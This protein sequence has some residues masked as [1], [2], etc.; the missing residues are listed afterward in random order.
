MHENVSNL[1][2]ILY[3]KW[4]VKGKHLVCPFYTNVSTAN[5]LT[6]LLNFFLIY[7]DGLNTF[8]DSFKMWE[9]KGRCRLIGSL[10]H[11]KFAVLRMQ[12]LSPI[13]NSYLK[14]LHR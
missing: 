3:R 2:P 10:K 5:V 4:Y 11:F 1:Y 9:K 6:F 12:M 14:N 13:L 7:N 8:S